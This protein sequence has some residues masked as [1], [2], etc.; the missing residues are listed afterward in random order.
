LNSCLVT[1]LSVDAKRSFSNGCL[2]V[3]HL[4]HRISTQSFQA[5]MVIGSWVGTPVTALL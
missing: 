3:N 4:Q 5:Q 1:A 2:M